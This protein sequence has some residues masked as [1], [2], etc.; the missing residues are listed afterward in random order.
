MKFW[1]SKEIEEIGLRFMRG[2]SFGVIAA[3]LGVSREQIAGLMW[4]NGYQRSKS[5]TIK[6][7]PTWPPA[8]SRAA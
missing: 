8:A 1:S 3:D 5:K 2:D 4:R 7:F 6:R